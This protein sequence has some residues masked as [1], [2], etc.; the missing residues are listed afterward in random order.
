VTRLRAGQG[1]SFT[2]EQLRQEL[3]ERT[4]LPHLISGALSLKALRLTANALALMRY[5]YLPELCVIGTTAYG[6]RVVPES[7]NEG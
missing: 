7:K 2:P 6:V 4:D 1:L 5:P 3:K